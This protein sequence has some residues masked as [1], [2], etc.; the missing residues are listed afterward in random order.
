M[1]QVLRRS[2]PLGTSPTLRRMVWRHS[3]P[4]WLHPSR[5]ETPTPRSSFRSSENRVSAS[6]LH[7]EVPHIV[8]WNVS[9]CYRD[10]SRSTI[11]SQFLCLLEAVWI[12][13]M[14]ILV[15]QYVS[16]TR[17]GSYEA[18]NLGC[19]NCNGVDWSVPHVSLLL[20]LS[21]RW[22]N[23]LWPLWEWDAGV[24]LK[25]SETHLA[26]WLRSPAWKSQATS[27]AV[28]LFDITM[29]NTAW[30]DIMGSSMIHPTST[31]VCKEWTGERMHKVFFTQCMTLIHPPQ[32]G[33]R[34]C[35]HS[36]TEEKYLILKDWVTER[37][38][39]GV[40]ETQALTIDSIFW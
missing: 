12:D 9:N 36:S 13:A 32:E 21:N 5:L 37:R 14:V 4:T 15:L 27:C 28:F 25:L 8:H 31:F 35:I 33:L 39:S 16:C 38:E 22:F 20:Q 34:L 18:C 1:L 19:E 30:I 7:H 10:I 26:C 40:W 17:L 6:G 24:K 23:V 11:L 2:S 3:C 29:K